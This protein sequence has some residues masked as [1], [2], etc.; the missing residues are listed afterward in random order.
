MPARTIFVLPLKPE[1]VA[2]KGRNKDPA[3][4][5]CAETEGAKFSLKEEATAL[6]APP[7]QNRA[8]YKQCFAEWPISCRPDEEGR[9]LPPG[10]QLL[11]QK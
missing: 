7:V 5:G 11:S 8:C 3:A 9:N 1:S 4:Q 6:W 10:T 2:P